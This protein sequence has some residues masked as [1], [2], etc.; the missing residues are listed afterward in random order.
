MSESSRR[1]KIMDML[2]FFEVAPTWE[3]AG[4]IANFILASD[5]AAEQIA[6][7]LA[8]HKAELR[9]RAIGSPFVVDA[10][11]ACSIYAAGLG[12][13]P[14]PAGPE[15]EPEP[16]ATAPQGAGASLGRPLSIRDNAWCP[17]CGAGGMIGHFLRAKK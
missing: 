14:I 1:S 8:E 2:I 3:E 13:S 17:A 12:G 11:P 9:R 10:A 5:P 7:S 4:R 15:M 6:T 16:A